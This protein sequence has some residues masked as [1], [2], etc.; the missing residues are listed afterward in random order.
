MTFLDWFEQEALE[1]EQEQEKE[2]AE[3][4]TKEP[5]ENPK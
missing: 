2:R 1:R 4:S 5:S 3:Q